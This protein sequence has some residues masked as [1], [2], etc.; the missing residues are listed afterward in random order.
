VE[1]QPKAPLWSANLARLRDSLIAQAKRIREGSGHSTIK[2][3]SLEVILRRTFG[4]YLPSY[5][6]VGHGQAVNNKR[7]L[8]P[9]LDVMVYDQNVFPHLAVN[10]DSSV[11]V[12]CES[13]F[14]AVECKA[15]RWKAQEVEEHFRK[16][17]KV[18]SQRHA[19]FAQEAA[20]YF[21]VVF[22]SLNLS[23]ES[24]SAFEDDSRTIGIYSVEGD[25]SWCS[26]QGRKDFTE[27]QGNGLELLLQ[28]LLHECMSRGQKDVGNFE[29]AHEVLQAYFR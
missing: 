1:A 21:V 11:V 23:S 6:A 9:Q 7:E 19:H 17:V 20:A 4:D 24:H 18:E 8:S 3:T 28:C 16:F 2:G 27:C 15:A 26:P 10:E 14:A 13:L 5:F 25:K 29:M 12:C 22:D